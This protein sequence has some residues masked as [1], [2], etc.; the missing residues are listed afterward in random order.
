MIS[1][2]KIHVNREFFI[3]SLSSSFLRIE[4]V[5][6]SVHL[7]IKTDMFTLWHPKMKW[8]WEEW[9]GR[10][11]QQYIQP[12]LARV[13]GPGNEFTLLPAEART[14]QTGCAYP[15]QRTPVIP[16]VQVTNDD[17]ANILQWLITPRLTSQIPCVP[18][19][20]FLFYYHQV[21]MNIWFNWFHSW[22]PKKS[23]YLVVQLLK[24]TSYETTAFIFVCI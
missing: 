10:P 7:M 6:N 19:S 1:V 14:W 20:Q 17:T 13:R 24:N 22:K 21:F 11:R 4:A 2:Y 8:T 18:P 3:F 9:A 12:R 5:C 15:A 23:L 16:R